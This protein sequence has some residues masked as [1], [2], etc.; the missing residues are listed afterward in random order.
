MAES[1]N[2]S[3]KE[4]AC[5]EEFKMGKA[6][7]SK[8]EI[9]NTSFEDSVPSEE[10][11]TNFHVDDG[12]DDIVSTLELRKN[13]VLTFDDAY[14][15][16]SAESL[17]RNEEVKKKGSKA[18]GKKKVLVTSNKTDN[19]KRSRPPIAPP[20]QSKISSKRTHEYMK[21]SMENSKPLL[22]VYLRVRPPVAPGSTDS[23]DSMNTV[24][25]ITGNTGNSTHS[26]SIRTYPPISSNTAKCFRVDV[27]KKKV[28]SRSI[29]SISTDI[30]SGI[31]LDESSSHTN[32]VAGVKEFDFNQVFTPNSQQEEIYNEVAAPLVEALFPKHQS[33]MSGKDT[34]AVDGKNRFDG[35]SPLKKK[36]KGHGGEMISGLN[37]FS[38]GQSALL[39]AYGITN[40]G[41]THTIVG[42]T[43]SGV[44]D[45]SSKGYTLKPKAGIL[46][47]SL[48]HMLSKIEEFSKNDPQNNYVM[49]MS[50]LEIY[51]E[52]IYDLLP[53][54]QKQGGYDSASSAAS[55]PTRK[56]RSKGP[57]ALR[58][59]EDR[60][61]HIFVK[62]LSKH[63]I[64]R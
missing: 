55:V 45:N 40:A 9:A 28:D 13:L 36:G 29:N 7:P 63:K 2:R 52:C 47:R 15:A 43:N 27:R 41:K 58:L 62:G 5:L 56:L 35:M 18:V 54:I 22:S 49:Y 48:A 6:S 44:P 31:T 57:L 51:N 42:D 16:Q 32:T 61:G 20:I 59:R 30:T 26:T 34:L 10:E 1:D 53:F 17:L 14:S 25:I 12:D 64:S 39:F 33:D 50:Y 23:H 8:N 4:H 60:N 3:E 38:K 19:K 24:E 37:S 11:E 46:P 21:K